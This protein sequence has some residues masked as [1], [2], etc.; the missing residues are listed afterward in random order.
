MGFTAAGISVTTVTTTQQA[1]LGFVLTAPCA[2]TDAG[3]CEWVYVFNDEASNAFAIGNAVVRDPSVTTQDWYGGIQAPMA[4]SFAR[5]SVLFWPEVRPSRLTRR[6]LLAEARW[7]AYSTTLMTPQPPSP[8]LDMS[9]R[10]F[11]PQL[12]ASLTSTA[13]DLNAHV[14]QRI[15]LSGGPTRVDAAGRG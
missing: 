10:P 14:C 7:G 5:A 1:P 2:T 4:S 15:Y 12:L 13:A 11:S 9:L 6:S 3:M 8:S